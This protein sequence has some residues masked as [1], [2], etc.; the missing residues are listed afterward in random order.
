[1][2]AQ[3]LTFELDRLTDPEAKLS[4]FTQLFICHGEALQEIR[5]E[6]KNVWSA[7]TLHMH[8]TSRVASDGVLTCRTEQIAAE[9]KKAAKTEVY[10]QNM[11]FL[12]KYVSYLKLTRTIERNMILAENSRIKNR[13]GMCSPVRQIDMEQ[14]K[15]RCSHS[16]R[17][18]RAR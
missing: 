13:T 12:Q 2:K 3:E 4:L 9:E 6:L 18:N 1:M 17:D 11:L 7:R 8:G 5:A 14:S 10:E 15:N 16:Y